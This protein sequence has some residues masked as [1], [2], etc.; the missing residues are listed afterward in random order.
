MFIIQKDHYNLCMGGKQ[1]PQSV[2]TA[3]DIELLVNL[4]AQDVSSTD[5]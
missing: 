2:L 3:I 1:M 4:F 5:Q